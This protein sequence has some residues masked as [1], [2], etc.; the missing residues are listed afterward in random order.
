MLNIWIGRATQRLSVNSRRHLGR[1][2]HRSVADVQPANDNVIE[3]P[4]GPCQLPAINLVQRFFEIASLWPNRIAVVKFFFLFIN[5]L[6]I[7]IKI[8]SRFSSEYFLIELLGL[9]TAMYVP[10]RIAVMRLS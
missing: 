4:H 8:K 9:I 5:Y 10:V 2:F 1:K 7:R 3:S 6:M